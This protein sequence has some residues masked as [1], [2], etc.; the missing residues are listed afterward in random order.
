MQ[1]TLSPLFVLKTPYPSPF[2]SWFIACGEAWRYDVGP[3]YKLS[4]L[5]S[6]Y[7]NDPGHH[8]DRD[9]GHGPRGQCARIYSGRYHHVSDQLYL[10]FLHVELSDYHCRIND[11]YFRVP[12]IVELS[13]T[14]T[15]V[16]YLSDVRW[17]V[18]LL[19]LKIDFDRYCVHLSV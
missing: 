2:E 10:L 4:G 13:P 7:H 17:H 12:Y 16:L 3:H 5:Y 19:F 6:Q 1:A 8:R 15:H 14:L 9:A 11:R 18:I